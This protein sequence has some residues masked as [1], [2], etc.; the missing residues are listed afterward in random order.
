MDL[1]DLSPD[2]LRALLEWQREMGV[3]EA[4]TETPVDRFALPEKMPQPA[5]AAPLTPAAVQAAPADEAVDPVTEA[6]RAAAAAATLEDLRAAIERYPHCDLR[7][8][9][10]QVVFSD[11]DPRARVML[12]GEAPGRDEDRQGK[13]FVGQAGQLL[14]KMLDAIGMSRHADDPGRSLYI[15]NLL[16][17][18]PE[19]NRDPTV[20]ETA[21]MLPFLRRH[22]ELADPEVLI[23]M[24]NHACFALLGRRGIT[25]MRG[26]WLEAMGKPAMPMLHTAYL[27][28]QP[29]AK[30][31]A[32]E[33]LLRL[34]DRLEAKA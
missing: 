15:T 16:P 25:K 17:W 5:A 13:P 23:L 6:E 32:W 9:A 33:D 11:G 21:M 19:G 18:R 29:H 31:Q 24:G 34:Q 22:V 8:G 4:L 2:A 27:L 7:L 3:D 26:Q 20:E 12:I 28:R 30:R 10:K 14:D 1:D